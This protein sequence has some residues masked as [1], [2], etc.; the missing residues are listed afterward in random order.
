MKKN[1]KVVLNGDSRQDYPISDMVF[2]P[3]QLVGLLSHDMTLLSGD[4]ICVGTNGG[5]GS[6]KQPSNDVSVT[7]DD[8]GTLKNTFKN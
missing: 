5:V 3:D 6:M 7:I 1:V 4:V 8:I 2:L